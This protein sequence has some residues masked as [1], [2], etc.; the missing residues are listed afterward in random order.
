M[1][2]N[3]RTPN[4]FHFQ[5]F[6]IS[7]DRA[8]MKIGIDSVL[9]GTWCPVKHNGHI[10][11]IGT[12][13]GILSLMLAQRTNCTIDAVEINLDAATQA[14]ENIEK[15]D[16]N[17]EITVHHTSLQNYHTTQTYETIIANPPYFEN[18]LKSDDASRNT[19]RHTDTLSFESLFQNAYQLLSNRGNFCIIVPIQAYEKINAIALAIGFNCSQKVE[20]KGK[21]TKIAKRVLLEFK[22]HCQYLTES[23][24]CIRDTKGEYSEQFKQL[25]KDFYLPIM[26]T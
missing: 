25:T 15:A 22:K 19:A 1:K 3:K 10:L 7:Q 11:D 2:K 12:G 24:I 20:V 18:A 14:I 16:F 17:N 9:L 8:A 23:E 13:T 26:F 5:Q 21:T 4:S 6:S